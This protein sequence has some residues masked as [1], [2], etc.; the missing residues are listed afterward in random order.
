MD[1][2]EKEILE[3]L[4]RAKCEREEKKDL[5][6]EA[7]RQKAVR[8]ESDRRVEILRMLADGTEKFTVDPPSWRSFVAAVSAT[9]MVTNEST[10]DSVDENLNEI[11]RSV[12]D[13]FLDENV[14]MAAFMKEVTKLLVSTQETKDWIEARKRSGPSL[15]S[16]LGQYMI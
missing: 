12:G 4:D 11:K 13:S 5:D 9:T 1:E 2:Q 10:P 3:M 16:L 7:L 8:A 6:L 14:E 15:N